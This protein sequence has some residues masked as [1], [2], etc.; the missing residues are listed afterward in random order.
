MVAVMGSRSTAKKLPLEKWYHSCGQVKR[1]VKEN[2][3]HCVSQSESC[4]D[5]RKTR[6]AREETD[7]NGSFR[8][9]CSRRP[10]PQCDLHVNRSE[11]AE[12]AAARAN[13]RCVHDYAGRLVYNRVLDDTGRPAIGSCVVLNHWHMH[14]DANGFFHW[15]VAAPLLRQVKV[16][17]R[18]SAQIVR[19]AA[20]QYE[21][22][23][24]KVSFSQLA[25]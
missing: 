12:A 7:G 16:N 19:S 15:S 21:T 6:G 1:L 18:Y 8:D 25:S 9:P 11:C 23:E 4:D 10:V 20:S 24:R 14:T 13:C 22:V 2:G 5:R 3:K 17:K